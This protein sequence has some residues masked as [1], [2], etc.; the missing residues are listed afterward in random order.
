[1]QQGVAFEAQQLAQLGLPKNN[2]VWRPTL[3][4]TESAAFKVVVGEAKYTQGGLLKGTT[5][6]ATQ[7]GFLEIKGGSSVLDSTYQLRLQTYRSLIEN[8]P[9]TIQT[10]RPVNQTFSDWLQRWG[11][12][13][14]G[15]N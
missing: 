10:T 12:K 1:M 8:K 3:S 7:G 15:S 6:D 4:Q 13:V 14:E 11:V 2:T 9:F 5:I